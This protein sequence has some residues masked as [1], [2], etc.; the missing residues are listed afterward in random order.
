MLKITNDRNCQQT[1]FDNKM[2]K[3]INGVQYIKQ[4]ENNFI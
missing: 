4:Y 2:N 1:C 3:N